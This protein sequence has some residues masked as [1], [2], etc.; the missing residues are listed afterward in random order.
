MFPFRK[1]RN[2]DVTRRS[3]WA[4]HV[5]FCAVVF[6]VTAVLVYHWTREMDDR[7]T[8]PRTYTAVARV[9]VS[10]A[11]EGSADVSDFMGVDIRGVLLNQQHDIDEVSIE[12]EPIDPELR[13]FSDRWRMAIRCRDTDAETA[14]QAMKRLALEASGLLRRTWN[15]HMEQQ[16]AAAEARTQRARAAM[17]SAQQRYDATFRRVFVDAAVREPSRDESAS[18]RSSAPPAEPRENPAWRQLNDRLAHLQG[19]RSDMLRQ[20]TSDHPAVHDIN[21]DIAELQRQLAGTPRW[22]TADGRPTSEP[23]RTSTASP[24]PQ[25]GQTPGDGQS[26]KAREDLAELEQCR[27]AVKTA[28]TKYLECLEA[29]RQ[30]ADATGQPFQIDVHFAGVESAATVATVSGLSIVGLAVVAGLTMAV[31]LGMFS[32]GAAMEPTLDTVNRLRQIANVPVIVGVPAPVTVPPPSGRG[33]RLWLR[34][35]LC[36]GGLLLIAGC[37]AMVWRAVSG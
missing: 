14:T 18:A 9:E 12:Q 24:A 33:S 32:A 28:E 26:R 19:Q 3:P 17:R 10:P 5:S 4:V 20:R 7:R 29:E 31:G 37:V 16:R 27:A 35:A 34:A 2:V 1:R 8:V 21:L 25:H 13:E 22:L 23:T 15:R 30:M 6:I 36:V 11:P